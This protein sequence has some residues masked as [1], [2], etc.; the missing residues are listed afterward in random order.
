MT[1]ALPI[2]VAKREY[3]NKIYLASNLLQKTKFNIILGEKNKVYSFFKHNKNIFLLSKGGSINRFK[4]FKKKRVENYVGILDEEGP[5]HNLTKYSKKSRLN[6]EILENIDQYF[7][8]GLKDY[9]ENKKLFNKYK[10]K[11]V[12]SG[13][14][15][16]DLLKKNY[17]RSFSDEVKK[18]KLKHSKYILIS[19]NFVFDPVYKQDLY[20]K[21]TFSNFSKQKI[22]ENKKTY[23]K[24]RKIEQSNYNNLIN[25]SKK[26]AMSNKKLNII[27]RPHP[28][29][30]IEN[31][32]KRFGK[33]PNNLKII[34][35]GKITPWIIGCELYIHSGCTTFLEASILKKKIIYFNENH[36]LS[37]RSKMFLN[38]KYYFKDINKCLKFVNKHAKKKFKKLSISQQPIKFVHNAGKENF[39]S[40]LIDLLKKKYKKLLLNKQIYFIHKKDGQFKKIYKILGSTIKNFFLK[41][42]FFIYFTSFFNPDFLLTKEYKKNKFD[43]LEINQVRSDLLKINNKIRIKVIELEKNLFLLRNKL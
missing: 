9:E 31:V 27:F 19:S 25:I 8:W 4:F 3:F 30:S 1:I 2:E 21:Y 5:I 23:F 41:R 33:V 13:H 14:P 36:K 29:E 10:D 15:K 18:I 32:L 24:R 16:Y 34:F 40:I 17:L 11:I 26:I 12:L 37:L 6:K 28:N 43:N 39:S 38:V 22:E 35:S 7:I 20:Y 42:N